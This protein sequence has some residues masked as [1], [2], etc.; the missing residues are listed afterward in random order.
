MKILV[1][2]GP[3]LNLLGARKPEVYGSKSIQ[4]I[5][6]YIKHYFKT[7]DVEFF[8]S[9][10]EGEIVT[11]IH[12][13][14]NLYNGIALNAAALTHYSIAVHDAIEAVSIPVAEVH[15]SNT[16]A[17]EEFRHKSVISS[18]ALGTISG[19]GVYS[20]ILAIQGLA[21]HLKRNE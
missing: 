9:N 1:I 6:K 2:H 13:A 7:V 5:N 8:Q 21:H 14:A 16:A 10:H 11:K 17:R 18:V 15:I 19:F 12:E 20:Y 4:E 3:N